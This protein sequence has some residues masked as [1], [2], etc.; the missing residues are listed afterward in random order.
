MRNQQFTLSNALH[1]Y[2]TIVMS[3]VTQ[4]SDRCNTSMHYYYRDLCH[5]PHPASP[6]AQATT[7]NADGQASSSELTSSEEE[8]EPQPKPKRRAPAKRVGKSKAVDIQSDDEPEPPTR[9][10]RKAAAPAK[11]ATTTKRKK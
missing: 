3:N 2:S 6:P 8:E 9:P 5:P 10:K 11:K 1:I 7:S 4:L